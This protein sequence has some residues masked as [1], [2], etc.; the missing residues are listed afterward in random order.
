MVTA[1]ASSADGATLVAGTM[2]GRCRYYTLVDKRLEYVRAVSVVLEC[3]EAGV[4]EGVG[5][6]SMWA[7]GKTA[8]QVPSIGG[9][10]VWSMC[11]R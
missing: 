4:Q 11:A 1:L 8:M 10:T 5:K 9:H 2:R 7:R 3:R 6:T